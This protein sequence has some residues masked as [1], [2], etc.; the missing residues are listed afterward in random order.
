PVKLN[1]ALL[2]GDDVYSNYRVSPDS[3]RVVFRAGSQTTRAD[4]F[5]VPIDASASPVVLSALPSAQRWVETFEISPDGA[6]V[7]YQ[8]NQDQFGVQELFSVP[9]DHSAG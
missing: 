4:L 2:A 6:R 5:G 7:V 1:G 9:I 8:A 3:G